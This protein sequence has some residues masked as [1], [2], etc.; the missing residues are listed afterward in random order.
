[1]RKSAKAGSR[2]GRKTNRR[3]KRKTSVKRG[4]HMMGG[5]MAMRT[6]IVR[7]RNV[8]RIVH[9]PSPPSVRAPSPPRVRVPSPVTP[10]SRRQPRPRA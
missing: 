4:S 2:N 9:I 1:M 6:R 8:P 5:E 7:T 10:K 3:G